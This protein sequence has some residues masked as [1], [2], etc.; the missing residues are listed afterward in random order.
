MRSHLC[1]WLSSVLGGFA[2]ML[3]V[4]AVV[5]SSQG[6]AF[7]SQPPPPPPPP[8][9]A[10]SCELKARSCVNNSCKTACKADPYCEC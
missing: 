6:R 4:L 2:I 3:L 10:P 7:A 5:G 8:P 1:D 9:P